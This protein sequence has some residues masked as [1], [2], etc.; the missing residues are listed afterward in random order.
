MAKVAAKRQMASSHPMEPT[1]NTKISG[2]MEGDAS[3][4]DITGANGTPLGSKAVMMGMTP[5]EQK[6]LSAPTRVAI[7][8][9][10]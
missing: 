9:A 2:S 10:R 5:Q 6:G 8:T 4:K 3:Q 7:S 1:L